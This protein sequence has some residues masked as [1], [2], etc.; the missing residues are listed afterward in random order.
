MSNVQVGHQDNETNSDT[1]VVHKTPGSISAAKIKLALNIPKYSYDDTNKDGFLKPTTPAPQRKTIT[2]SE[3]V[4]ASPENAATMS[5][6]QNYQNDAVEDIEEFP[7]QQVGD[8]AI[9]Q[10]IAN[11][12]EPIQQYLDYPYQQ[13]Q[14]VPDD[15]QIQHVQQVQQVQQVPQKE[16]LPLYQG[17]NGDQYIDNQPLQDAR[18]CAQNPIHQPHI[19]IQHVQHVSLYQGQNLIQP[20]SPPR[21]RP[22][23]QQP[24][25]PPQ[26]PGYGVL[27]Q[28][29]P[30]TIKIAEMLIM[31]G[32]NEVNRTVTAT[33]V[34]LQKD[35][36]YHP[37]VPKIRRKMVIADS[38]SVMV[39]F[40]KRSDPVRF[41]ES[42]CIRITNSTVRNGSFMIHNNTSCTRYV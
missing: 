9:E 10:D 11:D 4:S 42:D 34:I 12:P 14:E 7:T 33:C 41:G 20:N 15:V 6:A 8:L 35:E 17:Q 26:Y 32:N 36:E 28:P 16:Q 31:K 29:T 21:Y 2:Y 5:V 19:P 23:A 25:N 37:L 40:V 3:Q 39:G 18:I 27:R 13:M 1:P 22:R 30:N 24:N 38:T